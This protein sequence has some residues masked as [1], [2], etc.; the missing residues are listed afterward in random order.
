MQVHPKQQPQPH[1]EGEPQVTLEQTMEL[2]RGQLATLTK[3]VWRNQRYHPRNDDEPTEDAKTDSHTT[4]VT[5]L[6]ILEQVFQGKF[7]VLQGENQNGNQNSR[8]SCLSSMVAWIM[9]NSWIGLTKWKESLISM[10][11]QIPRRWNWSL[12]SWE[13]E[14][15]PGGNNTKFKELGGVK[16]RSKIGARWSRKWETSFCLSIICSPCTNNCIIWS[17]MAVWKSIQRHFINW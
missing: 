6:V 16:E 5:Q 10:R 2:L 11:Y 15:Q 12:S 8:L 7:L 14:L 13:G 17:N 3:E 1:Q 9:K 4:L